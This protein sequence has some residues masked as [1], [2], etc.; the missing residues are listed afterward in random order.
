MNP[1]FPEGVVQEEKELLHLRTSGSL[2]IATLP[3]PSLVISW[4]PF[5]GGV[6]KYAA[7]ILTLQVDR[8]F[9]ALE[10]RT[11]LRRAAGKAGISGSFVGIATASLHSLSSALRIP[12]SREDEAPQGSASRINA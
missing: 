12:R 10:G 5:N 7:H 3:H 2:L 9:N 6:R 8:R 4:A 1:G 11:A